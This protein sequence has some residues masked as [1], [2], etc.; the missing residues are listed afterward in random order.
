MQP[1]TAPPLQLVKRAASLM[2]LL[3]MNEAHRLLVVSQRGGVLSQIMLPRI[4]I[5][6]DMFEPTN[7]LSQ[8]LAFTHAHARFNFDRQKHIL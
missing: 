4:I 7:A 3:L 2:I 5:H 1:K 8:I 6:R